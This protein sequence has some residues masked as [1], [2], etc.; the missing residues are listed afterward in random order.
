MRLGCI[1]REVLI[2]TWEVMQGE[3]FR[4]AGSSAGARGERMER[5]YRD[6]SIGNSHRNTLLRDWAFGELARE[7][8]GLPRLGPGNVQPAALSGSHAAAVTR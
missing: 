4:T 1:A 8:L 5:I 7:H 2:Q 3:I 6:M